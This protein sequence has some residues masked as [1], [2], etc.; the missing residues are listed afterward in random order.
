MIGLS[1]T[2]CRETFKGEVVVDIDEKGRCRQEGAGGKW[3]K[4]LRWLKRIQSA[5]LFDTDARSLLKKG[6][7]GSNLNDIYLVETCM[8]WSTDLQK[9]Q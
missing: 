1:P 3:G 4:L 2:D 5:A 7:G 9:Q 8:Q 6:R